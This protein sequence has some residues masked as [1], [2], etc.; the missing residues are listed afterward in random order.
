ML[1]LNRFGITFF[2]RSIFPRRVQVGEEEALGAT[3]VM[4]LSLG[5]V[6]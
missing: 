1:S 4:V 6:D 3:I 2:L 5:V